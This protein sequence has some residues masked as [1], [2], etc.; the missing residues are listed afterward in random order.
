M[1][2]TFLLVRHGQSEWNREGRWQGLADPPLTELGVRQAQELAEHLASER[3]DAIYASDL[4]RALATAEIIA[5]PRGL[6]VV[7]EPALREIDVG[8]WSGLT[9]DEIEIRHPDGFR[10]HLEGGDGWEQGEPHAEM[11]ARIVSAIE[12]IARLHPGECVLCVLH[13]G[14]IRALL[15][16]AEGVDLQAFRRTNRGPANGTVARIAVEDLTFSRID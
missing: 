7:V 1:R 3:I 13:G 15:A 14:V 4:R 16:H 10:R 5:A 9:T 12:R 8:E 6:T 11:S 2:T